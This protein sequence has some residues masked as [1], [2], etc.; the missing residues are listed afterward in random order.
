MIFGDFDFCNLSCLDYE[1]PIIF[2]ETP[3]NAP[4][5]VLENLG[6]KTHV[7]GS[8]YHGAGLGSLLVQSIYDH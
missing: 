3:N 5:K 8:L 1:T 7:N 6:R 2:P 4:L